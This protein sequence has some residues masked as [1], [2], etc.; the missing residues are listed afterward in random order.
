MSVM[1]KDMANIGDN[2]RMEWD[3]F[4]D[5]A[6]SG[7]FFGGAN[8][9]ET[10]EQ[11]QHL[12]RYGPVLTVLAGDTGVGKRTLVDQLLRQIDRDLFDV[13]DVN[14]G[15]MLS[16]QQLLTSLEEPWRS[17]HPITYDNYMELVPA[18]ASAADEESKTLLCVVR[19]AQKMDA[20]TIADL[21]ALLGNAAGLPIKFLLVVGAPEIERA[22]L[23]HGLVQALPDSHVLYLDPFTPEQTADY[24]EFRL[25]AAGLGQTSLSQEQIERIH[26]ESQGKAGRINA[27]A[28]ELVLDAMPEPVVA[29]T[30]TAKAGIPW[31]HLGALAGVVVVLAV[32]LLSGGEDEA[33]VPDQPAAQTP[34]N[35]TIV[36]QNAAQPVAEAVPEEDRFAEVG[37]LAEQSAP[38]PVV[39]P[40]APE[41]AGVQSQAAPVQ[42]SPAQSG[43][44]QAALVG[45]GTAQ[46]VASAATGVPA[47]AESATQAVEAVVSAPVV[48][49]TVRPAPAKAEPLQPAVTPRPAVA[50][51][52]AASTPASSK[53]AAVDARSR[54]LL[55]LSPNHYVL[56][57]MG[58]N[59]ETTIKRFLAQYPSLK[60]VSYYRTVRQG[61]PWYVVVQ[62]DYPDHAAAKNA[63]AGLPAAIR[64]QTPWVRQVKLIQQELK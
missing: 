3:P 31:L 61:K 58:A 38:E 40:V 5:T 25:H 4:S 62:G 28:R 57:L 49:E 20:E 53:P 24:L 22:P 29:R 19:E 60:K 12:L 35:N 10:I 27:V 15:V 47:Q 48:A 30:E 17:L 59:E 1:Q 2:M 43:Q 39:Q 32:L 42:D 8:R 34:A 54:W 26:A 63:I 18:L 44:G 64:N 9:A 51:K 33:T 46:P 23:V 56:Q 55:G 7:L 6:Q 36:L 21:N 14:A 37:R 41:V 50:A 16:F 11:L 45:A 13:A 52:P